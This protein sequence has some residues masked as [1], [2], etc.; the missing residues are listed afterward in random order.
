L[1]FIYNSRPDISYA[2]GLISRFMCNPRASHMAATKHILRYLKETTGYGLLFPVSLNEFEDCLEAWSD[3]DWC[4]DKVG[5][6]R[7][8]EYFFK[9]LKAPI[10]WCSKKQTVVALSSCEAEYIAAAETTCQCVWLEYVLDDLKLD[11]VK[12]MQLCVDNQSAINLA[13]N[14]ISHGRSKH[15]ETKL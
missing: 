1:R 15:I 9:Y 11:H 14:P 2:V 4:G 5:R 10:S 8:Y 13:K 12:S 6:K 3:S 7:T